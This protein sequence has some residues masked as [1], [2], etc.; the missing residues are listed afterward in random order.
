MC[1]CLQFVSHLNCWQESKYT[2]TGSKNVSNNLYVLCNKSSIPYGRRWLDY[3]CMVCNKNETTEGG[4]TKVIKF[5][6][7]D[8][9][10]RFGD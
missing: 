8:V 9:E 1:V 4:C 2:F 10:Y 3:M 6:E 7:S 5:G